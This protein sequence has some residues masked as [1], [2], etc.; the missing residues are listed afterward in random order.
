MLRR[1][2]S[3]NKG[4]RPLSRSK[5]TSS[6]VRNPVHALESI[7]PAVAERDAGIAAVLSYHRAQERPSS[8]MIV[9]PRDPASF[10]PDSSDGATSMARQSLE[11]SGSVTSRQGTATSV[12]FAGPAAARPRRNLALRASEGR[13]SPT[14]A[15]SRINVFGNTSTRPSST[16]SFHT[17]RPAHYSLTRRYL[18]SLQPPDACYSPEED[19]VSMPFS[20]RKLRKSR[21]MYTSSRATTTGNASSYSMP[22]KGR[23]PPTHSLY[24]APNNEN[25]PPKS[26]TSDATGLRASTSMS[27]LKNRRGMASRTSSRAENDVVVRLA[28][29]K[30]REQMEEQ[31]RLQ[32]QSSATIR[33]K[34][35][36]SEGSTGL[37]KSL[38]NSSNNSTVLSSA[39]SSNGT[40]VFK[41]QGLRKTARKV[42]NGLR[43]KLKGLFTRG[44]SA[45]GSEKHEGDQGTDGNDSDGDTCLHASNDGGTEEASMS[46]VASRIPSLHDVP[47]NQQLRSTKGS[48]ESLES[49]EQ[50]AC[51]ERS[52]VTSWTNS[53]TNTVSSMG[54]LGEWERQ[55]LSVIKENGMHISSSSARPTELDGY[56]A[57]SQDIWSGTE[58]DSE[59]VYSALM[60]RL[61]EI[62]PEKKS[63][64]ANLHA[65]NPPLIS[66]PD[67]NSSTQ[68][69]GFLQRTAS[70]IRCVGVDDDVF[71]DREDRS[72][73]SSSRSRES[74]AI[75]LTDSQSVA[76]TLA[77][78]TATGLTAGDD[79]GTQSE[80]GRTSVISP[81]EPPKAIMQRSSAFFASPT[82]HS[83]RSPSPYRRALRE[84]LKSSPEREPVGLAGT[85]YLHSLSALSLPTRRNS[86]GSDRDT[87]LGDAE[88]VYSCATEDVRPTVTGPG[89]SGTVEGAATG[90]AGG[91]PS[92]RLVQHQRDASTASSVEWKTWLSSKVS[93]LEGP[94]TPTKAVAYGQNTGI[95]PPL[96]HVR[97]GAE[98]GSPPE[99]LLPKSD[100][101]ANRSPLSCVE[102][103][104]QPVQDKQTQSLSF[105]KGLAGHDENQSPNAVQTSK[106]R[107]PSIPPRSTL[108]TV[109]SLPIVSSTSDMNGM[110]MSNEVHRM[111]SLN[112]TGRLSSTPEEAMAK[113]RSRP[114]F[115]GWQGSPTKSSPG[116]GHTTEIQASR[117]TAGSPTKRSGRPSN[118]TP[119]LQLGR[120]KLGPMTTGMG[121]ELEAQGMGSKTMVDIF[122]SSRRKRTDDGGSEIGSSPAAFL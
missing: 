59:R 89:A 64:Q 7:D 109:P 68:H 99:I 30:Y 36:R 5:S 21:S 54:M 75:D 119:K 39:F 87:Q 2:S 90:I 115:T 13:D 85:K 118:S 12:R 29:E 112:I 102:G 94:S 117:S 62:S 56:G 114:R 19:A 41:Q 34:N 38:R 120:E 49:D 95:L 60:K 121:P 18:E 40:S 16:M 24:R 3:R 9:C 76:A 61:G 108:R 45:S 82:C 15:T 6:V 67:R 43:S 50:H 47:S 66:V 31:E 17:D 8:E 48:V 84:S 122:L 91:H 78:D 79:R 105:W 111:R 113:R 23:L 71:H 44:K 14:K 1:N 46:R 101:L 35:R 63:I 116:I 37:R 110:S 65:D 69:T 27:F 106:S 70:T 28:R 10:F 22:A 4:R 107:P 73:F 32:A 86:T 83:F 92:C 52:R 98:V 57:G 33:S 77:C 104:A 25:E 55:R 26:D 93:K 42:S 74:V 81:R 11:R 20:F 100:G 88:S 53:V 58:I 103:N 96:G 72:S 80:C 51:D 97:E